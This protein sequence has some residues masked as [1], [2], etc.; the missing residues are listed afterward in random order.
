MAAYQK[1]CHRDFTEV[2]NLFYEKIRNPFDYVKAEVKSCPESIR[3]K[4]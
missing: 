4:V 3:E 1:T 2:Y